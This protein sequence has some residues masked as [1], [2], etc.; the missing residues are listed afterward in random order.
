MHNRA[1]LHSLRDGQTLGAIGVDEFDQDACYIETNLGGY[2]DANLA[3]INV[4]GESEGSGESSVDEEWNQL[5][6]VDLHSMKAI[7]PIGPRTLDAE[8]WTY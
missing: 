8:D 7:R 2:L 4:R 5:V 6:L 3:I 1:V